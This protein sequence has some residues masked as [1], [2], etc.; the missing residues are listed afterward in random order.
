MLRVLRERGP[1]SKRIME[2]LPDFD[3]ATGIPILCE[4]LKEGK[5]E[6]ALPA[7][8]SL[9][10]HSDSAADNCLQEALKGNGQTQKA[11]RLVLEKRVK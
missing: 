1:E 11:V 3:N 10:S 5:E 4:I 6:T 9:A 7:A 8:E 2:L